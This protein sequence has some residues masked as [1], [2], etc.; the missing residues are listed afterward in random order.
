MRQY[1]FREPSG[2]FPVSVCHANLA[3]KMRV[4]SFGAVVIGCH[5]VK[6]P[7]LSKQPLT[8]VRGCL[9]AP[10]VLIRKTSTPLLSRCFASRKY[11]LVCA[12]RAGKNPAALQTRAP[13]ATGH[14]RFN[15]SLDGM[16]VPAAPARRSRSPVAQIVF[17]SRLQDRTRLAARTAL[18]F[19]ITRPHSSNPSPR[20]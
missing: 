19:D 3:I 1:H 18:Y 14:G 6:V 11:P 15:R 13:N 2:S 7:S 12:I 5:S 8:S 4:P 17:V 10:L 16:M 20:R 9:P